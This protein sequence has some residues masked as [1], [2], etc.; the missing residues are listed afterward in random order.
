MYPVLT[1]INSER[2]VKKYAIINQTKNRLST[3]SSVMTT[4]N[5]ESRKIGV[6]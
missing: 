4:K 2:K 5:I 1:P 6:R 3:V